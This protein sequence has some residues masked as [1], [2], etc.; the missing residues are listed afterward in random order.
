MRWKTSHPAPT[1][2]NLFKKLTCCVTPIS[3]PRR[4]KL[5]APRGARH[6][7]CVRGHSW[8]GALEV[9]ESLEQLTTFP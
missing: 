3:M 4:A 2:E 7:T 9:P 1:P 6:S 5:L 8:Q